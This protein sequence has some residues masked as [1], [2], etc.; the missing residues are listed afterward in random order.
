MRKCMLKKSG[1]LVMEFNW[2][3]W[4]IWNVLYAFCE[5]DVVKN[6]CNEIFDCKVH[7]VVEFLECLAHLVPHPRKFA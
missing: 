1:G 4:L 2:K 6:V 5:V 7:E 3:S